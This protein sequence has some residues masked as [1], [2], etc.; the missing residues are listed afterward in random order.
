VGTASA[1]GD[2]AVPTQQA[3]IKAQQ[4]KGKLQEARIAELMSQVSAI[5]ASLKTNGRTG[6]EIRTVKVPVPVVRQ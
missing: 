5:Q 2:T 3:Q 6:S 1:A 4:A